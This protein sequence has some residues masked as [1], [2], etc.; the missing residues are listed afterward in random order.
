M[1]QFTKENIVD[2]G[3]E[4]IYY[5][6]NNQ[7][8]FIARFK[9]MRDA[10]AQKDAIATGTGSVHGTSEWVWGFDPV[11]EWDK[12]PSVPAVYAA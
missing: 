12:S 8:R 9:H 10:A 5:L 2:Y 7:C 1:T 4:E 6:V 11:R 3:G